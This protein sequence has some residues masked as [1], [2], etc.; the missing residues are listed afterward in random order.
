MHLTKESK[1]WR[2]FKKKS[3]GQGRGCQGGYEQRMKALLK[4]QKKVEGG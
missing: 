4:L 2:K 1:L 3:G